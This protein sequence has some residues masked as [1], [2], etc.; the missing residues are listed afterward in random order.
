MGCV[1]MKHRH[2]INPALKVTWCG[3]PM[4]GRHIREGMRLLKHV[5]CQKCL[6]MLDGKDKPH[7]YWSIYPEYAEL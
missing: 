2:Y 1:V 6:S 4:K 5:N 7:E 3:R